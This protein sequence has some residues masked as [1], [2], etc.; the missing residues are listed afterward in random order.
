MSDEVRRNVRAGSQRYPKTN[1]SWWSGAQPEM[2][3]LNAWFGVARMGMYIAA[4][5][6]LPP[7]FW[8]P[9]RRT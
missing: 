7:F 3:N 5:A 2:Q 6:L 9:R 4:E 8:T 1:I